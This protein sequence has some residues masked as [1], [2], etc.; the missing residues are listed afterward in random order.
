MSDLHKFYVVK[1]GRSGQCAVAHNEVPTGYSVVAGPFDSD[2]RAR[3][4][5]D[6]M[7]RH[8]GAIWRC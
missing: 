6:A 3:K 4:Q 8:D 5:A 7:C 1:D 2:A